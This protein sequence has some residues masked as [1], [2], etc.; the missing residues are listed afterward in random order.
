MNKKTLVSGIILLL[1]T[2]I[3]LYLI[4]YYKYQAN[5]GIEKYM[6]QQGISE[7][8]IAKKSPLEKNWKSGWYSCTVS[9]SDDPDVVYT[10]MYSRAYDAGKVGTHLE[11]FGTYNKTKQPKYPPLNSDS[12][13]TNYLE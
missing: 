2:T 9:L 7:D 11:V 1:L 4:P 10:Y 5:N 3:Y 12:S 8:D 6:Q 13:E